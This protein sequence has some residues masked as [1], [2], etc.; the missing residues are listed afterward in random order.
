MYRHDWA[1]NDA[2]VDD[3]YFK[4]HGKWQHK[5]YCYAGELEYNY[6]LKERTDLSVNLMPG[7]P[8]L[9]SFGMGLRKGF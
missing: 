5:F 9:V 2:Y 1:D 8:E 3:G 7:I 6:R 4:R